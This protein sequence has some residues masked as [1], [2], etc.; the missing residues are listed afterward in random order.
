M[1]IANDVGISIGVSF[2]D[3]GGTNLKRGETIWN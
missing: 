1:L 2:E 3:S